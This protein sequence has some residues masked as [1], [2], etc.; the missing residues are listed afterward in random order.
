MVSQAGV[1]EWG[2]IALQSE[3]PANQHCESLNVRDKLQLQV[4]AI[5]EMVEDIV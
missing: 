5:S 1:L 4:V 3:P 2:A